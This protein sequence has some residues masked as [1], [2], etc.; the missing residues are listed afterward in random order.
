MKLIVKQDEPYSDPKRYRRLMGKFIYLTITRPDISFAVGVVSQF[1]QAP[2][3]DHW[4]T[5]LCIL[6]YIKKTPGQGLLYEDKG[7]TH[8]SCYCVVDWARSSI[9]R[10]S[11][12]GLDVYPIKERLEIGLG[13]GANVAQKQGLSTLA[14]SASKGGV[15]K[16]SQSYPKGSSSKRPKDHLKDLSSKGPKGHSKD[17]SSK[18]SK[19]HQK[20]LSSKGLGLKKAISVGYGHHRWI[21][22][23]RRSPWLMVVVTSNSLNAE[24][25]VHQS[26]L[27]S[28]AITSGRLRL[29]SLK[30][31][32]PQWRETP[33]QHRAPPRW[34]KARAR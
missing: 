14:R 5:V 29:L 25:Q 23:P 10:R 27:E 12:T 26:V 19:G 16:G 6:K 34:R 24:D 33:L 20:D 9:D 8:I 28:Q 30:L 13:L 1:M 18:G 17:S 2:C 15:S 3:V 4:T 32:L 22:L 31:V 21:H 11:S 7:D